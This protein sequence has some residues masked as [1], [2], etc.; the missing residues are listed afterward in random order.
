[1]NTDRNMNMHTI[2]LCTAGMGEFKKNASTS[3]ILVCDSG[4]GTQIR[5]CYL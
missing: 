5:W 1:M 4:I 3:D 2:D